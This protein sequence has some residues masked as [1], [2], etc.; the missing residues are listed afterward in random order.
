MKSSYSTLNA[1]AGMSERI[2]CACMCNATC[3]TLQKG[4]CPAMGNKTSGNTYV[5]CLLSCPAN[6]AA[7]ST[8]GAQTH[9][10]PCAREGPGNVAL[11]GTRLVSNR[12]STDGNLIIEL[13]ARVPGLL[14]CTQ[15]HCCIPAYACMASSAPCQRLGYS[16]RMLSLERLELVQAGAAAAALLV[17]ASRRASWKAAHADVQLSP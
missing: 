9:P 17:R 5:S 7:N 10:T 14:A 4:D 15:T 11:G 2:L 6:L 16:E 1:C 3:V 13:E 12:M 8:L